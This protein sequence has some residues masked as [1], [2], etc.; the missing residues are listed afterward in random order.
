[1]A[2]FNTITTPTA[3]FVGSISNLNRTKN[4][5]DARIFQNINTINAMLGSSTL[6]GNAL[7]DAVNRLSTENKTL[8]NNLLQSNIDLA[9]DS[10]RVQTAVSGL[11]TQ[12]NNTN[13][14]V[15]DDLIA[16]QQLI[17]NANTASNIIA[18]EKLISDNRLI[19]I[20]SD[21]NNKKRLAEVN[22]YYGKK[23]GAQ[24]EIMKIIIIS[25][26][27]VLIIWYV[28][29]AELLPLPSIVFTILI[30]LTITI[31]AVIVFFKAYYLSIRNDI[32]FDQFD[33][34]LP[35][36]KLPP[37]GPNARGLTA[38]TGS[39]ADTDIPCNQGETLCC[40]KGYAFN[41]TTLSC[42]PIVSATN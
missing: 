25:C 38:H 10:T 18:S 37:M 35:A 2:T 26:I 23:Y 19:D 21:Y 14:L 12:A 30:S 3:D 11:Y 33:F 36:G 42:T 1:M 24:S 41:L 4:D 20:S 17:N 39:N 6:S 7:S 27:I 34:N 32:D 9:E 16:T 8:Y 15:A 28:S 40:P 22:T 31:A 29:S 5:I 13:S